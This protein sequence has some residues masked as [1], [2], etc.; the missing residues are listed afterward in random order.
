MS[1]ILVSL[2]DP[3]LM[4]QWLL[5]WLFVAV[6]RHVVILLLLPVALFVSTPFI[7]LRAAFLARG[8]KQRFREAVGE[9]YFCVWDPLMR[10]LTWPFVTDP[11]RLESMRRQSS[12]QAMQPT[13]G[14]SDAK[15]SR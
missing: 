6:L 12:N 1:L 5:R 10:A 11:D 14:R 3:A 7:V 13:A 4:L 15:F 2:D 8:K 9:G